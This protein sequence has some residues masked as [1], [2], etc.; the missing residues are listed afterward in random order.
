MPGRAR[1]VELG[2]HRAIGFGEGLVDLAER[3]RAL[4]GDVRSHLLVHERAAL[5]ARLER[6][7]HDGQWLVVDLDQVAG[8]LGDVAVLGD[9]GRDAL[10]V[11][12][13]L[14]DRDH[15]LDD[16]PGAERGQRIGALGDVLARDH[17]DHAG[18]LLGGLG[19]DREDLRVGV[20]AADDRR[21][22][23]AGQ[24]DVVDVAALAAQ[25]AGILD[26]V[27]AL[28]EPA[29]RASV[30]AGAC[31]ARPSRRSDPAR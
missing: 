30:L 11:V 6:I 24:L 18:Q 7:E 17:G 2:L 27:D 19:A 29:P 21:V 31:R 13:H 20:R 10:A 1:P 8:V 28:A 14:L 15:V 3:E 4:V 25:E 23:H 22:R 16:R 9:H 5:L 12:A 26:A